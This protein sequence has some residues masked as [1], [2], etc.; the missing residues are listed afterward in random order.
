MLK[1]H[2]ITTSSTRE[3][4]IRQNWEQATSSR[5]LF[6]DDE[7]RRQDRLELMK[8]TIARAKLLKIHVEVVDRAKV[9]ASVFDGDEEYVSETGE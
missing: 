4:L 3:Q 8:S 9:I 5:G 6:L 7:A 2:E 1:N